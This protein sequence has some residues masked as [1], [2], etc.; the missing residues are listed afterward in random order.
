MDIQPRNSPHVWT[1]IH[2][3]R[4]GTVG[5]R[6]P[7]HDTVPFVSALNR[8]KKI[9]PGSATSQQAATTRRFVH[10]TTSARANVSYW[11]IPAG[12]KCPSPEVT[13]SDAAKTSG[14]TNWNFLVY[15]IVEVLEAAYPPPFLLVVALVAHAVLFQV[16]LDYATARGFVSLLSATLA[17]GLS[18]L[19]GLHVQ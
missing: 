2:T 17:A 9:P 7:V 18:L 5:L 4:A 12:R 3:P 16:D 19:S 14:K 6:P 8:R 15:T 10:R 13:F 1:I 11:M